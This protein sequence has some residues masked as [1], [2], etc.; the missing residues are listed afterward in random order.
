MELIYIICHEHTLFPVCVFYL[1]DLEEAVDLATFVLL[2]L[3]L[4]TEALSLTLLNGIRRLKG[5]AT[6][7]VCLTHI[8][9]RVTAPKYQYESQ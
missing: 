3:H 1:I 2:L 7:T 5:P 9:T 4:L 8:I 6:A